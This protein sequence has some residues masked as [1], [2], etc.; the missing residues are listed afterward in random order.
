MKVQKLVWFL[1]GWHLAITGEPSIIQPFEAWQY[2]P[3][4]S[5]IY[6]GLKKFGGSPVTDYIKE[7][8]PA[9]STFTAY[10]PSSED[11]KFAEIL[12][13]TWEKYI[14]I[15]AIGLSAMTHVPGS[16]W[17]VARQHGQ[18]NID[19]TLIKNYFVGLARNPTAAA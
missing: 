5:S 8:D 7:Y 9:T 14:G 18:S 6:H 16:P 12:D 1:N 3:V 17:F 15:D 4:V 2:G 13:L 10:V 11:K 19:N